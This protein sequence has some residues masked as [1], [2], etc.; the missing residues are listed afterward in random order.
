MGITSTK[1]RRSH[2]RNHLSAQIQQA[3]GRAGEDEADTSE[4]KRSGA[5]TKKAGK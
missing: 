1:V 4:E 5:K 2:L 3:F